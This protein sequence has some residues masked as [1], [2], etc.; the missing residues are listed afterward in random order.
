VATSSIDT[1]RDAAA[2]ANRSARSSG[3]EMEVMD[4]ILP[5]PNLVRTCAFVVAQWENE[6][7]LRL[8]S[9]FALRRIGAYRR[10]SRIGYSLHEIADPR[11][12]TEPRHGFYLNV[13]RAVNDPRHDTGE[14]GV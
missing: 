9:D 2:A 11:E 13:L 1:P 10:I 4:H 8:F 3:M 14:D 6:F 7:E 5:V 12:A